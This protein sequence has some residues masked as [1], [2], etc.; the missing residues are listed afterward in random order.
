MRPRILS[1]SYDL[2]LLQTRKTCLI[3]QDTRLYLRRASRRQSSTVAATLISSSWGIPFRKRTNARLLGNCTAKA[4]ML[5]CCLYC[6]LASIASQRP[7]APSNP[8]KATLGHREVD[9]GEED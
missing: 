1:I 2:T 3:R 7:H 8:P 5:Q 6:G 4:A 9:A